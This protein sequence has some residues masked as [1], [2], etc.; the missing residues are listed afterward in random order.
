[1]TANEMA[2]N[3]WDWGPWGGYPYGW[4]Y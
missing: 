3:D 2:M 4:Y 1:M